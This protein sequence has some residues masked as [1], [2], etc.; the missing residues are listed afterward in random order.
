MDRKITTAIVAL[1]A[2]VLV[3]GVVGIC[4]YHKE[5]TVWKEKARAAFRQA[6]DEE[7]RR[8]NVDTVFVSMSEQ[9][10]TIRDVYDKAADTLK[11]H[12]VTEQGE[13]TLEMPPGK[14]DYNFHLDKPFLRGAF[15][16]L[17][18]LY[19]LS[20]DTL[21][22]HWRAGLDSFGVPVQAAVGVNH[23]NLMTGRTDSVVV[24]RDVLALD[25]LAYCT[26]GDFCEW[27]VTALGAVQPWYRAFTLRQWLWIFLCLAIGFGLAVVLP[28]VWAFCRRKP[29]RGE[30]VVA[31][32]VHV[33]D[34]L[35]EDG[36]MFEVEQ[37]W[38]VRG[39]CR[40][41]LTPQTAELLR[42]LLEHSGMPV[43]NM[44]LMARLWPDGSG[45]DTRL[46]TAVN[47]L[48]KALAEISAYRVENLR[49]SYCLK[50]GEKP[51][52]KSDK[53]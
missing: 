16:Y 45:N 19:P 35:L 24:P 40:Q 1:L 8:L 47:R 44:D 36:T 7:L 14:L 46:H 4:I 17:L 51:C 50:T 37:R 39:E 5:V 30:P 41:R 26:V 3:A 48:N 9:S 42:A 28:S 11:V 22:G 10:G 33:R 34:I 49:G 32:L 23:V 15:S 12:Y 29:V 6:L 27:E 43:S 20:A 52:E 25:T 21:L 2:G 53:A 31:E 38:L 13:Q 18:A